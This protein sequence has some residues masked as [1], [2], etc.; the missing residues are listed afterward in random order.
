MNLDGLLADDPARDDKLILVDGLDREVGSTT[1]LEAH[2]KGLLHRAFSVVLAREGEGG[3][4]LLIAKRSLRKY[5]S[6]G[7]WANSVC[8]HPRAGEKL[9]DA[10]YRRVHEELGCDAADLREISAFAYRAEFD[11][12]LCEHEFDHVL[13]GRH[14]GVIAPDPAEA[15]EVSWVGFDELA[16]ALAERPETFAAWA[17]MVL[18]MAM[19]SICRP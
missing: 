5:H 18:T 3:P 17:P 4:E 11:N 13:V 19:A 7:L 12:G 15:S 10:A 8:S 2:V 6:G 16:A 1:K 9:I 14:K